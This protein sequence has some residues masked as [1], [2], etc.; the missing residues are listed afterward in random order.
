MTTVYHC[1]IFFDIK[2]MQANVKYTYMSIL[3]ILQKNNQNFHFDY[4]NTKLFIS[5]F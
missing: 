1:F 3:L 4:L 2:L 5:I